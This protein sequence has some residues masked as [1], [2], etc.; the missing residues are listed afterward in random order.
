MR[1]S[2]VS[3]EIERLKGMRAETPA[4][5]ATPSSKPN[6]MAPATE[7]IKDAKKMDFPTAPEDN[8]VSKKKGGKAPGK[9]SAPVDVVSAAKKKESKLAKLLKMMDSDSE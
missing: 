4:P 1:V 3:A 6:K 5:A 8:T 2:D 7:S 9:S